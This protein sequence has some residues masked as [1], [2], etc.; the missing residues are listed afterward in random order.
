[1]AQRTFILGTD[2]DVGKTFIAG[3]L[4]HSLVRRVG[5]GKVGVYKPV[6][7]GCLNG[8]G[9]LISEDAL[10]LWKA[11]GCPLTLDD[12][13]PQR[14]LA[15]LSPPRAAESENRRIDIDQ[16]HRGLETW[17]DRF[18]HVIV[19]GAGGLLS[20][21]ADGLLNADFLA[22][23]DSQFVLVAAN[24]LGVINHILSAVEVCRY[25][26]NRLP[27]AIVMN[28]TMPEPCASVATNVPELR[29]YITDIPILQVGYAQRDIETSTG[30]SALLEQM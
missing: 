4:A 11:A 1:M 19:E 25:R 29:R 2:T 7:S 23:T 17:T 26:L 5:A 18:P 8:D 24:R 6:A 21:L 27:L 3:L 10:V 13:C 14:F 16:I 20:P 9:I 15:P 22:A 30:A 12:V 28:Q